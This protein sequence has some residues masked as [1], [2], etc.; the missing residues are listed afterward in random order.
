MRVVKKMFAVLAA[1]A[2]ALSLVLSACSSGPKID[3]STL[4]IAIEFEHAGNDP[5]VIYDNSSRIIVAMYEDL[6]TLKPGTTEIAPQLATE[7]KVSPDGKDYTFTLRQ[8]VK[9][10][11]GTDL[12]SEAVKLS[13][14]RMAAINKGPAW[15]FAGEW[16]SIETPD[17]Q[18]VVF[19]LNKS[20]PAF[21]AKLAGPAG[22]EIISAKA[23]KDHAGTDNGQAW[24]L[25]NE[26]GTGPYTLSKW[27]RGQ[28]VALKKFDQ[29][30]GGWQ[31][32]HVSNVVFKYVKESS[33][34]LMLLEKG[35]IDVAPGLPTDTILDLKKN[36]KPGIKIVNG[37]T[38][39]ILS[40]VLNCQSG[41]LKDKRVR[42][43]VA[44]AVDY[45]GLLKNVWGG[46][47]EPLLGPLPSADPNHFAGTYSYK[48]DLA[49]AKELLTA[50][51]YP[52]GGFTLK[53]GLSE[54]SAPFRAIAETVQ[55]NLKQVGVDV[56]IETYAWGTLYDLE[57]KVDT[58][59]DLMPIGN[60]PDYA[61]SSSMLGNEFGSWAWG[62]NGWNFS[63]YK[64]DQ[65]DE[66][67]KQVN[68]TTDATARAQLFQQIQ[69]LI[70]DD[71]PLVSIGTRVDNMAMRD[72][73]QGYYTR[74]MMSNSYPV[75]EM[76]KQAK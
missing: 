31:G 27:D 34:Q 46:L 63:F 58:A 54:N 1:A 7:W 4:T 40:L 36:P 68:S 57:G 72:Y 41:P 17:P 22:P 70:V 62:V 48:F 18:T 56:Q 38:Q 13:L 10:H 5:A 59:L 23:I 6:V 29:Y 3:T 64:N 65:V 47:Y 76:Y 49:K 66:L 61:D 20:D 11:D 26:A 2:L 30:W 33:S 55:A 51:G 74:P 16:S 71:M 52:D 37:Q 43:A 44:Y 28:Q 67:L 19:H 15:M 42:Q 69:A 39:N 45:D 25:E 8:G 12:T 14:E 32:N 24:F 60:Y 53:L 73:V 50:A 35:E 9:F 75:Y 21:L